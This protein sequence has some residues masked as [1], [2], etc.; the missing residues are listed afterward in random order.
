[1]TVDEGDVVS[2]GCQSQFSGYGGPV[3]MWMDEFNARP[4][5]DEI[6]EDDRVR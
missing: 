1:M 3:L 5:Q 6:R 4:P 2:L